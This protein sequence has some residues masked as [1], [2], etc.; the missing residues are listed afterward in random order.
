MV[1][2]A[3]DYSQ[4]IR[5]GKLF[6]NGEWHDA[7]DGSAK[8]TINPA[9]EEETA[10]IAQATEADVNTAV[11]AARKAF[12]EG[13]WSKMTPRDRGR[14]LMKV[15][16]LIVKHKDELAYR[17]TIDN[18]KPIAY[19]STVDAP[20]AAEIYTY[21]G[22]MASQIEGSTRTPMSP[23]FN[24][25]R[26]EPIGV[27]AAITP[28]NFPLLQSATKIAPALAAGNTVI[29]KPAS[30]T[31][32]TAIKVA[33]LFA[34]AGIPEGVFNLITGSGGKIGDIFS[35]HPGIDKISFTGSTSVGIGIVEKSAQT[36]KHLTMEL[37]GKSANIIFA[38]ADLDAAAKN[39]FFGIFYNKGEICTAGSRLLVER[40][41][42]D[43]VIARLVQLIADTPK[44][45]PLDPQVQ[46]GPLADHSQIETVTK[47]VQYGQEDGA[48][49]YTG[50]KRFSPSG[51]NGRGFY[52][53]PTIFTHANNQMRI[54][55]EEIFGPVLTVIPFDSE[56]EAIMLA[57]D[58]MYGLA[59]GVH[60]R[61]LKKAHRV[62]HALK[63]GTC[64]VN[65]YN[66]YDP[67][68]PYGGYKASGY[69]REC[70]P[71]AMEHYTQMKSVW[72]DLS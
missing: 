17:E 62:A 57:N 29:H 68:T 36:L 35:K 44:G 38:D 42:H 41:V 19:S 46:F 51:S 27:V 40:S 52:Y 61:D 31:P 15:G 5:D 1:T 39:A 25:T 4:A 56:A 26:R 55:Q 58:S 71:E 13:A 11:E 18:G 59:S 43:E 9:T 60:T 63:A 47:Y 28:F 33:E 6:I 14:L 37:G 50:G 23:T 2:T 49:L 48:T 7:Q 24:Y 70:G 65:C 45:N 22:G 21:Y 34:E 16:E 72:I 69:G 32:L 20:F 66:Q 64:W 3:T 53:E 12:E 30:L 10:Q 8:P 54:A 67:T